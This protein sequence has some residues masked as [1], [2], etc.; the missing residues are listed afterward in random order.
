[1]QRIYLDNNATTQV[2]PEVL[3][4]MMPCY[5]ETFGNA[6]SVHWY[7]QEAKA[8]IDRARQ[9]VA[10]LLGAEPNEIV[11]TSGG[12][13]SDNL[14]IRGVLGA[15]TG[16]KHIIASRIEHHA[17]LHTCQVLQKE[18]VNVTFVPVDPQG[19]IDPADVEKAL[20]PETVLISIMHSNNEIGTIQAI[21][22]IGKIA[23]ERDIYF[24]TDA[25]QAAGKLNL[26]VT[27]L[28]VDL[29][30][31]AG[32]KFHAPKGVGAL[33]VRKGT[34]L[35]PLLYG[36]SHERNR[37]AGTENVAHIVGLGQAAELAMTTMEDTA[38][39]IRGLRDYFEAEVLKSIPGT[40]VNGSQTFRIPNTSNI[41]F[42]QVESEGMVINLDLAGV[43]CST[44]SA[45]TSGAIEP[46]HV[47][48][49]LGLSA[50]EAFS[51][52]RFSLSRY[53]TREEIDLL[54]KILPGIVQRLRQSVPRRERP[55]VAV[56]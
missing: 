11:F 25:V 8:L 34:R 54:L 52:V 51:S 9:Q 12:T 16:S 22:E 42:D 56:S 24:H 53:T 32:H 4:A 10:A 13:E 36:G 23:R 27:E 50:D 26:D 20:T 5:L 30:S 55:S 7:G 31:V 2:A 39:R 3:E 38:A 48:T 18:G 35:K 19:F 43:A 17:V 21:Q 45:C 33:Y 29:L 14:A 37:R 1:M 49:A 41:R 28:G 40:H 44:G 6:S 46:S 15:V 47:L